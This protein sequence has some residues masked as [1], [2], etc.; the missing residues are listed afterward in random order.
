MSEQFT[1]VK[2][3]EETYRVLVDGTEIGKLTKTW[4]RLGGNGWSI[5]GKST[6]L[7]KTRQQAAFRLRRVLLRAQEDK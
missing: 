3:R 4:H 7:G 2:E 1:F 6:Q 5:P